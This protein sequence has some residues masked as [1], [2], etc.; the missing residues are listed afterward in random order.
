MSP[1]G[2]I[3]MGVILTF[4]WGGFGL[5]LATALRREADKQP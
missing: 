5:V 2:W 3:T 1:A 4:V